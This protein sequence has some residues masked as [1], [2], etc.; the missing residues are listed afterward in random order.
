MHPVDAAITGG[1]KHVAS[2]APDI[3]ST[4]LKDCL[5]LA[6]QMLPIRLRL[7]GRLAPL[8]LSRPL[9]GVGENESCHGNSR[10]TLRCSERDLEHLM[11]A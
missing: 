7:R 11:R 2:L 5:K 4:Y 10:H 1:C 3:T 8:A 6:L 9:I